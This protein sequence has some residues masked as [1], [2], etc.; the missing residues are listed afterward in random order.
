V[1][2]PLVVATGNA[3]KVSEILGI[4]AARTDAP[5]AAVAIP[6]VGAV[7]DR[8]DRV[9][10]SAAAVPVPSAPIDVEETGATLEANALIKARAVATATG[11]LTIAD[12]SGLEV[13]A[14]G[15]APGVRSARYAG[16]QAT[17][18]DNVTRLLADL[19]EVPT[20]RRTARFAAV[21]VAR[22]PDG[23][24]TVV[25]GEVEG[26][27]IGAPSGAGGFGYD[28]VFVP[29]EG[30]GRTFAEMS[31]EEKHAISH[32]GRAVRALADRL[33]GEG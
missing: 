31:A 33:A 21:L 9:A 30:D 12:D 23:T 13:D 15:G 8:A 1:T 6:G 3:H 28:P 2:G 26:R 32:R 25:R 16:E 11:L 10:A 27:I 19:A 4:L 7:I 5:L 22:A 18:A 14:L 29:A 24:E 17:D 20:E